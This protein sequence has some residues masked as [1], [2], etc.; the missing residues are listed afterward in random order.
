MR[1]VKRH[2]IFDYAQGI[3]KFCTSHLALFSIFS[4]INKFLISLIFSIPEFLVKAICSQVPDWGV[5]DKAFCIRE[6]CFC[7]QHKFEALA[8]FEVFGV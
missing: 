8:F 4:V 1:K 6:H 3:K 7:R 2:E 5:E